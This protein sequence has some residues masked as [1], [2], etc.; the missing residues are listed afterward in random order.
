[1]PVSAHNGDVRRLRTFWSL[2]NLKLYF[3]AFV[4]DFKSIL[5]NRG[6]VNEDITSIISG[7]EPITFLLVK[8]FNTTFGH[9]NSPPLLAELT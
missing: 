2:G 6:I 4:K 3:I 7:N 5:L 1:M 9:Y 8:P